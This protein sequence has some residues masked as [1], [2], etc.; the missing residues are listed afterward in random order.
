MKNFSNKFLVAIAFVLCVWSCSSDPDQELSPKT[1]RLSFNSFAEF[2]ETYRTLSAMGTTPEMIAWAK[3]KNYEPFIALEND[4]D[5]AL[6]GIN[7]YSSTFRTIL[8]KDL[9]FE[10]AND[11]IWFHEGILYKFPKNTK[12]LASLKENPK[13]E[14]KIGGVT[15]HLLN[16]GDE[17]SEAGRTATT[18]L[19]FGGLNADNQHQFTEQWLT[20]CDGVSQSRVGTRK[21]V[22]EVYDESFWSIYPDLLNSYLHLRIKLEWKGSKWRPASE[23][24]EIQIHVTGSADIDGGTGWYQTYSINQNYSCSGDIDLRFAYAEFHSTSLRW[25]FTMNGSIYQHIV[26]DYTSNAWNNT[27]NVTHGGNLW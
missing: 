17:S 13:E 25:V 24:R 9:E 8:N 18:Y 21:Y 12:D 23:P 5:P 4:L 6:E 20:T 15:L 16:K 11:I 10:V 19:G 1:N 27:T 14:N 3:D 26:G 22:H 2:H 7:D